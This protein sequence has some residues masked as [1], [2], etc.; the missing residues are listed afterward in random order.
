MSWYAVP[1][2]M[3]QTKMRTGVTKNASISRAWSDT[4]MMSP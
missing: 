3:N 1:R 2:K 4:G